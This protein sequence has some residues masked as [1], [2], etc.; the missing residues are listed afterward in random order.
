MIGIYG[1]IYIYKEEFALRE[2]NWKRKEYET[3]D[4]AFRGL[5]PIIRQQS[6]RI[7]AYTQAIFLQAVKMNFGHNTENGKERIRGQYADVMYKCG[8]YHQLGKAQVPPEYQV[9]Q[10]DFTEEEIAVYRKY[11]SDGRLLV[12][13]LQEKSARA[14]EKRKGELIERPTKNIPW[15]IMRECCEQH[16]ERWDGTGYPLGRLSSD[17]SAPAQ[18][19]GIAKELDKIAS[20][21]RSEKPFE[22]AYDTIVSG[23][24]TL[25]APELIEVFKEA[26]NAC[27]AVYQKYIVYTRTLPTTIPLVERNPERVMGLKYRPFG[28]ENQ[29]YFPFYEAEPWFGGVANRPGDTEGIEDLHELFKRTNLVEDLSWYFLYEAADTVLRMNNCNITYEGLILQM[30]PEFYSLNAPISKF[31]TLFEDQPIS[32]DNLL[33]TVPESVVRTGT[34]AVVATV[35]KYLRNGITL[36][37][38]NYHPDETLSAEQVIAM[39][40]KYV[41]LA[42]DLYLTPEGAKTLLELKSKGLSVF[43]KNADTPETFTWLNTN[44]ALCASGTMVGVS[45]SEDEMILD[46]L[47]KEEM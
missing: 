26:K 21:T 6:V 38:D 25:W 47:A 5:A 20:E 4:E 33:L 31:N 17:I 32:K 16:M 42:S 24:G 12:A 23:V 9:L 45:V 22:I 18:I 27:Y 14:K 44:G 28:S 35:E 30:I 29:S 13:S 1:S 8:L 36:V 39:G 7:A 46:Y 41:S 15:L 2:K 3:W 11:T 40:F 43:G 37:L 34:K 10:S 19:V